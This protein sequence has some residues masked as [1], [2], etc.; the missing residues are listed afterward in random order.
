M[1]NNVDL[2]LF[3]LFGIKMPK[4]VLKNSTEVLSCRPVLA[5]ADYSL[6]FVVNTDASLDGLGAILYQTQNGQQ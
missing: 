5:Y 2:Q 6:P 4:V 1:T 3:L